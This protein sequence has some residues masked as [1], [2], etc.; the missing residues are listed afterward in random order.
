MTNVNDEFEE[1]EEVVMETPEDTDETI[2]SDEDTDE[3]EMVENGEDTTVQELTEQTT[4][5]RE[6]TVRLTCRL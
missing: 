3:I 5:R 1:N 6:Q 4:R 2:E